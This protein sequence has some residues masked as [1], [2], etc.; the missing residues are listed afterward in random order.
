MTSCPSHVDPVYYRTKYKLDFKNDKEAMEHYIKIGKQKGYFPNSEM[1]IFYCKMIN[2]DPE[3][4]KR[5]YC[6]SGD[7]KEAKRHWQLYGYKNGYY[8]NKCEEQGQHAPFMCK[9]RI[10]D[11]NTEKREDDS[12]TT[13]SDQITENFNV[14]S[15][16]DSF[17]LS[18]KE[19]NN[20]KLPIKINEKNI[21]KKI[22]DNKKIVQQNTKQNIQQNTK[23]NIQQ[24]TK[25]NTQQNTKQ[26]IHKN[27]SKNIQKNDEIS[28]SDTS[29]LS[30]SCPSQPDLDSDNNDNKKIKKMN[31]F[32]QAAKEIQ[33]KSKI[34]DSDKLN[35]EIENALDSQENE[36]SENSS[37]EDSNN[38]DSNDEDSNNEDSNNEDSN[39][40][41]TESSECQCS[42]CIKEE[43]IKNTN[44]DSL[45][46][47]KLENEKN[48]KMNQNI[49]L[50]E[51]KLDSNKL[52][53]NIIINN[54]IYDAKS[55]MENKFNKRN[56][57]ETDKT[58]NEIINKTTSTINTIN[59]TSSK[60][61]SNVQ[62]LQ[63][64]QIVDP[65]NLNNS[66]KSNSLVLM[67]QDTKI[68]ESNS[69]GS[70][71]SESIPIM[72]LNSFGSKLIEN[73]LKKF[74][75]S[76]KNDIKD[77]KNN[78]DNIKDNI[79]SNDRNDNKDNKN[80]VK[81]N[82]NIKNNLQKDNLLFNCNIDV[83]S[84]DDDFVDDGYKII[85][86]DS[87]S[88]S[89][90]NETN[91]TISN[92][93]KSND[94]MISN[95][96]SEMTIT[97]DVSDD[98]SLATENDQFTTNNQST[99]NSQF[100][101]DTHLNLESQS[102]QYPE[103]IYDKNY[104]LNGNRLFNINQISS[105]YDTKS[106]LDEKITNDQNRLK[107]I[108]ESLASDLKS[109]IQND[110]VDKYIFDNHMEIICQ[111]II[112]IKNYLNMCHIHL[113]TYL[114]ILKQS[115]QCLSDICNPCNNYISYNAARVKLCNMLKEAENVVRT[116]HCGDL[117]IFY[118]KQNVKSSS[119]IKF[120]FMICTND[121]MNKFLINNM[122][123][124]QAYFKV[125]LMKLSLKDLKLDHYCLPPLDKG[126][127][128][129]LNTSPI[130]PSNC[131]VGKV[132]DRN[133]Y[134]EKEMIKCWDMNYH[135]T[136]F[137]NALYK[138]TITK[139]LL[140][141]YSKM[142]EIKEEMFYKIKLYNLKMS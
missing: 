15:D 118:K 122:G 119:Y 33:E 131:P 55:L 21:D 76:N 123:D 47:K 84:F 39:N 27:I 11:K 70:N 64:S 82:S 92:E 71:S 127:K 2:F 17:I 110:I 129:S 40:E 54:S 51:N 18:E 3:Y 29:K 66:V 134:V 30:S 50:N 35:D 124:G 12:S 125:Q 128:I 135:L 7:N 93:T 9:C 120:P 31:I 114:N 77:N 94:E 96:V 115:Y 113:D 36:D 34:T 48:Y 133:M 95:I 106:S 53:K 19:P 101:Y 83:D 22:M 8:V 14:D 68:S 102:K 121:M 52:D 42:E 6:L 80:E 105:N 46:V 109:T 16:R 89:S 72:K 104:I 38:E 75:N 130:P 45:K 117:P 137:E 41:N 10:K 87:I 60:I 88:K 23:Q 78:K 139:E 62:T 74:Q 142:I 98:Y 73:F 103:C 32:N 49:K 69:S 43:V 140:C 86:N 85:L 58:T 100:Y 108:Q 1:E 81:N 24:N 57:Y 97:N 79:K 116:A 37:N 65:I 132:P 112:N 136:Q 61:N 111:N 107:R 99:T 44:H 4:Y 67:E 13:Y 5:K 91:Y 25:Q 26:N 126:E 20:N 59:P 138:V 28:D 56:K 141:N 90:I 63:M